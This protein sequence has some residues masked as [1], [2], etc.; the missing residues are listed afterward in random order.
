MSAKRSTTSLSTSSNER[1][2]SCDRQF[3]PKA[4]DRHVEWCRERQAR[5]QHSPA[6]V[7]VAKER[8]EARTK[9][10]VPP[11]R[12]SKRS[13]TREKYASLAKYSQS[14]GETKSAV[15]VSLERSPSVKKPSSVVNVRGKG[16]Q[17]REDV[18]VNS[19]KGV[20]KDVVGVVKQEAVTDN[21]KR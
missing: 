20:P 14:P 9:Y 6:S 3:G 17:R 4:F 8:L 13:M 21:V 1:C 15:N 12:Q 18:R 16:E 2:P 10:K 19:E 5:I 11:L 7:R